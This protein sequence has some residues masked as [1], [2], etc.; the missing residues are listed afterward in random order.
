MSTYRRLAKGTRRNSLLSWLM[1]AMYAGMAGLMFATRMN[2]AAAVWIIGSLFWLYAAITQR[3]TAT[4]YDE[5]ADMR[6]ENSV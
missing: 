3:K 5:I 4:V 2:W 6:A 1:V